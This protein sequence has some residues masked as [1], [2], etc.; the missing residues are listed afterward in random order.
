MDQLVEAGIIP[1]RSMMLHSEIRSKFRSDRQ[2]WSFSRQFVLV[3]NKK[4]KKPLKLI[5]KNKRVS[6]GE[7]AS[8]T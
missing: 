2:K 8:I 6:V 7:S 5:L 4:D 1:L 3:V